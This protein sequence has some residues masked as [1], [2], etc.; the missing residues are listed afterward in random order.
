MHMCMS[1]D[2]GYYADYTAKGM[3]NEWERRK[4]RLGLGGSE[5]LI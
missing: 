2:D 1:L 5:R 4:R 3:K